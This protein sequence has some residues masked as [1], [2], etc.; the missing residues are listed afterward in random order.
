M[1]A[2]AQLW[3]SP[4][5]NLRSGSPLFKDNFN[6]DLSGYTK[7]VGATPL[8]VANGG[9]VANGT[10]ATRLY[11]AIAA[12]GFIDSLHV[13]KYTTDSTFRIALM[14][15]LKRKANGDYIGINIYDNAS[16]MQYIVTSHIS[17]SDTNRQSGTIAGNPQCVGPPAAGSFR[18][19]PSTSYWLVAMQK[20]NLIRTDIWLCDPKQ[21]SGEI[22][23]MGGFSW[24]LASG[25]DTA[26]GEGVAASATDGAGFQV[27]Q[28]AG[29]FAWTIDDYYIW[30]IRAGVQP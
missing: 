29:T 17:G 1:A 19:R 24:I 4:L 2:P 20:G 13:L 6:G 26:F 21:F 15:I 30:D 7:Q 28:G 12:G 25:D 5:A 8:L 14:L 27:G 18:L 9:V 3:P 10:D 11:T 16:S 23:R 22:G